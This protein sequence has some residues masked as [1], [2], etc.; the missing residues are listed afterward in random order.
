VTVKGFKKCCISNAVDE[1]DDDMLW[2]G[3]GEDGDVRR[4]CKT[5]NVKMETIT[6]SSKGRQ[7]LTCFI[8]HMYEINSKIFFLTRLIILGVILDLEKYIFPWQTCF[9]G[10]HLR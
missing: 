6:L 9:L 8:Y 2:N 10:G 5:L 4:E 7:N 3:S 1:T